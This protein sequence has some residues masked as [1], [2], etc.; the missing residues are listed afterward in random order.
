MP[1]GCTPDF[2][3]EQQLWE[4]G[5]YWVAGVDEVGR[6]PLAGPVLAA[7]VL[8]HPPGADVAGV[9]D[10]KQ[11][12][13]LARERLAAV[14]AERLPYA[15]GEASV[16]EIDQLGIAVASR[17]AM[18]RALTRLPHQPTAV[19]VD[20]FRLPGLLLEQHPIVDGDAHCWSIAAASVLAK[21]ARDRLMD[22]LDQRYPGYGFA[23]HKGYAT[24]EHRAALARLGPCPVHRRSF[25]PLRTEVP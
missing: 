3:Y 8:I 15:L 16:E 2:A 12:S 11:L 25:A 7:A 20:G 21:V 17:L 5:H 4:R 18:V 19:L 6:G 1:H 9:A 23:R 24:A 13:P 14:L 22:D 10:S